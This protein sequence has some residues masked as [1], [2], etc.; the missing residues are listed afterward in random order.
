MTKDVDKEVP[1]LHEE[2][3]DHIGVDHFRDHVP[4]LRPSIQSYTLRGYTTKKRNH[5]KLFNKVSRV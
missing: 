2:P 4:S 5:S 1:L 3:Q